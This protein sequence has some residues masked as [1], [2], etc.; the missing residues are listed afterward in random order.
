MSATRSDFSWQF[1]DY[2]D[3]EKDLPPPTSRFGS[4]FGENSKSAASPT[5]P[6]EPLSVS[7]KPK[8]KKKQTYKL[9]ETIETRTN[10]R[11]SKLFPRGTTPY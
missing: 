1:D 4:K 9:R 8:R 5:P 10:E 6:S 3:N 11:Q 7:K 2:S